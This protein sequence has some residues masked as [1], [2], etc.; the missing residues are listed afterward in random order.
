MYGAIAQ[1]LI[2]ERE[3]DD[4]NRAGL[5]GL[6]LI[7]QRAAVPGTPVTLKSCKK[8]GASTADR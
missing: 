1:F 4:L 7:R 8:N 6:V 5:Y 2:P 3:N